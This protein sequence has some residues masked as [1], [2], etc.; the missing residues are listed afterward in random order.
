ML[1]QERYNQF[2]QLIRVVGSVQ[3]ETILYMTV[4]ALVR[5]VLFMFLCL[6]GCENEYASPVNM[7]SM[8]GG[9]RF[10]ERI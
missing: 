9:L 6:I 2:Q 7:A 5:F 1:D 3:N 10:A 8:T 4:V